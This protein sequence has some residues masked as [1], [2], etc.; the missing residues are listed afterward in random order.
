[1]KLKL[2]DVGTDRNELNEPIAIETLSGV[3]EHHFA[4][5]IKID[6]TYLQI[7]ERVET[8][9]LLGYDII[10]ISTKINGLEKT[11]AILIKITETS[12]TK[13]PV[14]ILG[15]L[16]AT[17]A[18]EQLL[19]KHPDVI[20]V[21]GEGEDA[22]IGI[23]QT[24]L[25]NPNAGIDEIKKSLIVKAV[26]NIAINQNSRI[27]I[28]NRKLVSLETLP[29]PARDFLRTVIRK[30]GLVRIEG[31]RGCSWGHCTFC[32]ISAKYGC[33]KWR[34][35]PISRIIEELEEISA[36]GGRFPYFTDEDFFGDD[37]KR[38]IRIAMAIIEAKQA[39]RIESDFSF[40]I[41]VP[42][43]SIIKN[44]AALEKLKQAGLKEIFVGV[45]SGSKKQLKRYGKKTN[46][47]DNA[48]AIQILRELNLGM[49]IGFMMFD[50]EMTIADLKDNVVFLEK[51]SLVEHG[52]RDIKKVRIEPKTGLER[53]LTHK[54]IMEGLNVDSLSYSYKFKD[55]AIQQ[56]VNKFESWE[57]TAKEKVYSLQAQTGENLANITAGTRR[58][59]FLGS[60]EDWTL[61]I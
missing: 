17:F 22:I 43:Q 54:K 14:I 13:K 20:C 11:E 30:K 29:K 35:F 50:P 58:L 38:T 36:A 44:K 3:L 34:P 8:K 6:M 19:L 41:N 12:V 16:L 59:A 24:I 60:L 1:M 46:V 32:G 42:A 2:I 47:E 57:D 7:T 25:H 31:S 39:G 10:G 23:T 45:E 40:Y 27:V 49:D 18:Y 21:T 56:I 9:D 28:T 48:K 5:S 52:E 61:N 4:S 15:G 33:A 26:P 53:R 55:P 51:L 37:A